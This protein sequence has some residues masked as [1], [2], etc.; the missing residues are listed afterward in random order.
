MIDSVEVPE[1]SMR[2][3]HYGNIC[4]FETCTPL[5]MLKELAKLV[6]N[7]DADADNC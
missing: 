1:L 5:V 2:I 7:N 6:K 4:L 3:M